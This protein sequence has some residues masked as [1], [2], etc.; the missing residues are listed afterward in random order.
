MSRITFTF[1]LAAYG[2]KTAAAVANISGV[3]KLTK[4]ASESALRYA[5]NHSN[6]HGEWDGLS[7][8]QS[9]HKSDPMYGKPL[10]GSLSEYRGKQV[11]GRGVDVGARVIH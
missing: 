10:P 4:S 8:R 11:G 3:G 1:D 9:L 5:G 2:H 7:R 6:Q